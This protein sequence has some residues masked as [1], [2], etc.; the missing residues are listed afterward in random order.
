[1][2]DTE[3]TTLDVF[4][5]ITQL[6]KT[7]VVPDFVQ[8]PDEKALGLLNRINRYANAHT[9]DDSEYSTNTNATNSIPYTLIIAAALRLASLEHGQKKKIT[10]CADVADS[11]IW[12]LI[13]GSQDEC[14]NIY[15]NNETL[16]GMEANPDI[17]TFSPLRQHGKTVTESDTQ[18]FVQVLYEFLQHQQGVYANQ[19]DG[20]TT[21]VDTKLWI[22][23]E[24]NT[25]SHSQKDASTISPARL[26][27]RIERLQAQLME[28]S[29]PDT[30][31]PPNILQER[32]VKQIQQ[33]SWHAEGIPYMH[34][35]TGTTMCLLEA[36]VCAIQRG[37]TMVVPP[38]TMFGTSNWDML[39]EMLA[40]IMD[41]WKSVRGIT[42]SRKKK[43]DQCIGYYLAYL[44]DALRQYKAHGLWDRFCA[45][46]TTSTRATDLPHFTQQ[47]YEKGTGI[48]LEPP[49]KKKQPKW[50]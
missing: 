7:P 25:V 40:Y 22:R 43:M 5:H 47:I 33:S 8:V 13:S 28:Y 49:L 12:T 31:T 50:N 1:M 27:R 18:Q 30:F 37:E 9:N 19:T 24:D 17:F 46:W 16:L 35:L 26:R 44:P 11:L 36:Y 14:L 6:H 29:Y 48:T 21:E 3:P 41:N 20:C 45:W 39:N 10:N 4:R 2:T 15:T 38:P 23:V 42:Q 32:I 34:F